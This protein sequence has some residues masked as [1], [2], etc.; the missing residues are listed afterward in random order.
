MPLSVAVAGASGYAGGEV[1]RL[2]ARHPELQVTAVTAHSN[3]G[4]LLGDVQPHLGSLAGLR[5]LET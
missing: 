5:L 2:L 1:L 3:A 4:Q